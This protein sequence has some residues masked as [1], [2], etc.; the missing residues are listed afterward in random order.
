MKNKISNLGKILNK[1][2]LKFINGGSGACPPDGCLVGGQ[3]VPI[4]Q[5]FFL[6]DDCNS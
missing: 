2:E 5:L 4:S 1:E 6:P 3:C